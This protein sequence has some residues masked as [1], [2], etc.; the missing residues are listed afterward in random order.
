MSDMHFTL[1][2]DKQGWMVLKRPGQEDLVD[3]RIRRSFPWS[4]PDRHVSIRNS[5]GKEVL[6]IEDLEAI[7]EDQ[8]KLIQQYLNKWAFIPKITRVIDVD[9]RFGFQAWKVE[10]DRGPAEF[11]VQEREDIRFLGDG[12][13]SIKDV[14]GCVYELPPLDQLDEK[15]RRAVEVLV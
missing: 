10:T 3:V 8:R 4:N 11:R 14:D 5:E 7:A 9:I 6:L 1:E 2:E 13:F 15:S 12:R